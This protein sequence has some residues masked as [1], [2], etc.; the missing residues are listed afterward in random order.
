M[1][2]LDIKLKPVPGES[3]IMLAEMSGAIDGTT[4]PSFQQTLED[5]RNKKGVRSLIL[6]MSRIKY[7]NSTGLGSLVKY[8]DGF[9]NSGGGMALIKVPAKVKIVIEML[10]LNAFFDI[11]QDLDSAVQALTGG[12]VIDAPAIAPPDTP[13]PT[14]KP[15]PVEPPAPSG[16]NSGGA[17]PPDT[18]P[19]TDFSPALNLECQSCGVTLEVARSGNFKCPRCHSLVSVDSKG[20]PSFLKPN[21]PAAVA[22]TLPARQECGEGLLHLTYS[23]CANQMNP[24]SLDAVRHA[25]HE[26]VQVIQS[27]IYAGNP[28]GMYH[29]T[30]GFNNGQVE[31]SMADHGAPIDTSRLQLYFPRSTQVMDK[32]ECSPHPKGGNIIRMVKKS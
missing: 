32:F 3:S 18:G 30:I 17:P 27:S 23:V 21:R 19:S 26:V 2:A 14:E 12:N 24:Q 11:C 16:G 8:A 7:V 9:K 4:V 25:V 10:G 5:I 31:I 6:D 13:A 20:K 1:S 29:V 15:K 28:E 22:L